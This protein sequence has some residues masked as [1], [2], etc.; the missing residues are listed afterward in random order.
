M[1]DDIR[2][3]VA[4]ASKWSLLTEIASKL[5]SPITNM[6][7]ARLLTPD[8]F[9]MIAT[10]TM[11][12][13]FADLFTDAGFQKY[14]VQHDFV[15]DSDYDK[16]SCVAFWA[17]FMTSIFLW[18]IIVLFRNG[19][20]T[21]VGNEGL[22]NA[23]AIAAISLPL[24]SFSSIQNARHKRVFDFQ[25]LF[26]VRLVAF[27]IP[28]II[29]IPLAF[30]MHS[31]WAL[32]IGNI[33]VNASNAIILTI[34]SKW[35]PKFYFKFSKLK[36]ML[37]FSLWTLL[38][39]LLGWANLN[40]GIFIVGTFISSYYLGMYKTSM[41]SV[42]QV[43]EIAVNALSPVLL[44]TLSRLKDDRNKF[45]S[46]FFSFEEKIGLIVIP[47]GAG[48][49]IYR[50]LFTSILL[51]NQWAEAANFI[52]LWACMRALLIVFGKFSME[53]LVS[54]GKPKFS[55]LTQFLELLCL[56]PVLLV[57]APMGYS[58]LYI[59]RS[60]IILWS[61]FTKLIILWKFAGISPIKIYKRVE[62]FLIATIIMAVCGELFNIMIDN[63]I[64]KF[65]SIFLCIIL[66]FSFLMI[67]KKTRKI[68]F[69]LLSSV[70]QKRRKYI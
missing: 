49:F 37:N 20:A 46:F 9:G 5:M 7:L 6:V 3:K 64:L 59:A 35:K 10:I 61:I 56:I 50:D 2:K 15:D 62:P 17:N 23:L 27:I 22:G 68:V 65:M 29:T 43:M 38:E 24:T 19:L 51:G 25:T 8:A 14:L 63:Y 36:E 55:V 12:T 58:Y 53:V 40:V 31:Y 47:L 52:G 44:S 54:L 70:F 26:Y 45:N 1:K 60:F 32:V 33:C 41:S 11:I 30:A 13:S 66:Y 28:L 39:Q 48:I 67:S 21:A 42:N 16:S 69:L 57:T 4:S 34:R 18:L